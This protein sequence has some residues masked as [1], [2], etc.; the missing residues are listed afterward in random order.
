MPQTLRFAAAVEGHGSQLGRLRQ[1]ASGLAEFGKQASGSPR[2]SRSAQ[3]GLASCRGVHWRGGRSAGSLGCRQ[4]AARQ[5]LLAALKLTAPGPLPGVA[6]G[7]QASA[8]LAFQR[9]C[10]GQLRRH[11]LAG[12]PWRPGPQGS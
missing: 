12:A 8:I 2:H 9:L 11:M 4:P 6:W 7:W 10:G 1:A 5:L 3:C